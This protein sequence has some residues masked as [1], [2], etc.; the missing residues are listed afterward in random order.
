MVGK[1]GSRVEI[2]IGINTGKVVIGNI[3]SAER[4]DY[5]VIG[6]AVNL[7]SVSNRW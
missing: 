2:G 6:D 1:I 7:R 3:G 5:T 4:M